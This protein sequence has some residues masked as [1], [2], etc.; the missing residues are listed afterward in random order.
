[1]DKTFVSR[2]DEKHKEIKDVNLKIEN[3]SL[4]QIFEQN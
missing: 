3:K 4:N 1:M 2:I